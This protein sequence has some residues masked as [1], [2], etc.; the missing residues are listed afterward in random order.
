MAGGGDLADKPQT[1]KGTKEGLETESLRDYFVSLVV[2]DFSPYHCET[3][4]SRPD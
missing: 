2:H 3:N 4:P 1:T